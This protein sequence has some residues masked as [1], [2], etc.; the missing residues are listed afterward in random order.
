MK[1]VRELCPGFKRARMAFGGPDRKVTSYNRLISQRM[2]MDS[3]KKATPSAAPFN[4]TS[5]GV[6]GDRWPLFAAIAVTT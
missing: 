1:S 6:A 4:A 5:A 3:V 2:S